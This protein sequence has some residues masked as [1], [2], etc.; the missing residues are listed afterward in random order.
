MNVWVRRSV[1][2]AVLAGGLLALGA[3]GAYASHTAPAT[4]AATAHHV[5]LKGGVGGV[6]SGVGSILGGNQV[7]TNVNAPVN[8][9][10]NAVGALGHALA[11][12]H[13][14]GGSGSG[15]HSTGGVSA[16]APPAARTA[17]V[18]ATRSSL[19]STPRSTSVAT[20]SATPSRAAR[21]TPPLR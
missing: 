19:A 6:T 16:A 3:T 21:S 15:A 4:D 8:V 12:C 2:T 5:V 14:G 1:Q 11:L 10:C 9:A 17:P 20:R 13:S 18:A 7:I